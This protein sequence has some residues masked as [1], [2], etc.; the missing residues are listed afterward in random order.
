M[1]VIE[2]AMIIGLV[3][4]AVLVILIGV[5]ACK[6]RRLQRYKE[7]KLPTEAKTERTEVKTEKGKKRKKLFSGI[8]TKRRKSIEAKQYGIWK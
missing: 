6:L 1:E 7:A 4:I 8:L 2:I 5:F 3:M